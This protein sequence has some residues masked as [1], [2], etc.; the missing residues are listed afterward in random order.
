[1][2]RPA[3][4]GVTRVYVRGQITSDRIVDSD[5]ATRCH[6]REEPPREHFRKRPD[7]EHGVAV[8]R[9]RVV[10]RDLAVCDNAAALW[11]EHSDYNADAPAIAVDA[12]C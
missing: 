1:M 7:F 10:D 11:G 6:V 2:L 4:F 5:F 8:D 12:L 9:T 3:P